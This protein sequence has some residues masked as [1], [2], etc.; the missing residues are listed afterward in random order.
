MRTA[1]M[2]VLCLMLSIGF[3][4][5]LN[6]PS[7][8]LAWNGS[9]PGIGARVV[10]DFIQR[11][12]N[13]LTIGP[14]GPTIHLRGIN[15]DNWYDVEGN[16]LNLHTEADFAN[17]AAMGMNVVRLNLTYRLFERDEAPYTYLESG[18]Q[19]VDTS[20]QWA[21][22]HGLYVILDMHVPQG[23]LQTQEFGLW[24]EPENRNRLRALWRTI[25]SRY[26]DEATVAGYD[27]LN[28]P[29]PDTSPEQWHAL[30]QQLVD[31]I[32]SVDP[33]HL[34]IVERVLGGAFDGEIHE[35]LNRTQFLVDDENA[36]YD[37][38]FYYPF[39]YTHQHTFWT[40]LGDGGIYPDP[41]AISFPSDLVYA[42]FSPGNQHLASG[43]TS[44]TRYEGEMFRVPSADLVA[45][46]P[47][48]SASGNT[49]T[50]YFDDYEIEEYD[51]S[52][53]FIGLIRSENVT[54]E[55]SWSF[56]GDG[57]GMLSTNEGHTDATSLAV[58]GNGQW[59][60][61]RFPIQAGNS[62]RISAW[63]RGEHIDSE[64]GI[65]PILVFQRSL[66]GGRALPRT[67]DYL[68][69]ELRRLTEFSRR[70]NVP[71]NVGEFGPSHA[72]YRMSGKGGHAY[73]RDL[74]EL[75]SAY[76]LSHTFYTYDLLYSDNYGNVDVQSEL[77][78]LL[79]EL[80]RGPTTVPNEP[81]GTPG[82]DDPPSGQDPETPPDPETPGQTESYSDAAV[83]RGRLSVSFRSGGR[84]RLTVQLRS[85]AFLDLGQSS[86][87]LQGLV[88]GYF[89]VGDHAELFQFDAGKMR[90]SG[91]KSV[92][93]RAKRKTGVVAI[94]VK[95]ADLRNA[96]ETFGVTNGDIRN[97][98]V[99][100]PL[101]LVIAD[102]SIAVRATA[103]FIYS[104][105]GGK[106]GR[107]KLR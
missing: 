56:Y 81:G 106:R 62:Y 20:I 26:R 64:A 52:G 10:P 7:D 68:E 67:R 69:W 44:W 35:D 46:Y 53:R 47:A 86:P 76:G 34:I 90:S 4:V 19:V 79:T 83:L 61:P 37:F 24:T 75:M 48:F 40:G 11:H 104:A 5:T 66:T 38:H 27:L 101:R 36:M 28:E 15:L 16:Y 13:Q 43:T 85:P 73:V 88:R 41:N 8:C 97:K 84:D 9:E 1:R 80:H 95:N 21:R 65:Q 3:T 42:D 14:G 105:K 77:I 23:G 57:A 99:S 39:N 100:I 33:N 55:E 72:T 93:V 74:I 87:E 91:G 96:L 54:S 60:G 22:L 92:L 29:F 25:A 63:M 31:E 2:Q 17:I 49:G 70:H 107:G 45:A 94:K 12:G 58:T 59:D 18:F 102:L 89:V 103:N 82:D 6:R 32:R 30:A 71:M 51:A 98:T 78:A 50:A